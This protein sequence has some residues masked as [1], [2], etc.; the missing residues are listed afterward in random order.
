LHGYQG[1]SSVTKRLDYNKIAPNGAK[2]L[3]G[4][5]GYV[6]QTRLLAGAGGASI[7]ARLAD[8]Q[9]RL[10]ARHAYP[11][12]HEDGVPTKK[13]ALIQAWED[14]GNLFTDTERAALARVETVTR[15]PQTG[16]PDETYQAAARS[17]ARRNSIA[18]SLVNGLQPNG[19]Q[20]P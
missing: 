14:G 13:L 3:G 19:D 16:V 8:Q 10:L 18:I 12:S 15:V 20:L 4:V 2:A 17:F 5:Y 9:L 1:K 6:T 7:S 11:R